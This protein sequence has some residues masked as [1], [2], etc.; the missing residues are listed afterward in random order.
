MNTRTDLAN[1]ALAHLGE[2]PITDIDDTTSTPARTCREF[3][4]DV[5]DEV[6][7]THRW[8]CA[9]ARVALSELADAPAHGYERAYQLP[10]DFLR[11]LE[12]NGEA[13]E[14][15]DEFHEIEA[16]EQLLTDASTAEIRYIRRIDV[17]EFDPLLAKCAALALAVEIAIPLTKDAGKRE[18]MQ[19]AFD[20]ALRRACKVDAVETGTRENRPL[21]RLLGN[22]PL[23]RSRG[24][25]RRIDP[26]RYYIP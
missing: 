23:I 6:L 7:R 16:G 21:E 10:A 18:A 9:T 25:S 20:A 14:A 12:V 2:E 11:L 17:P 4:G 1:R 13:W 5:I 19:A 8:N 15:S 22:S 3:A 24:V 26:L